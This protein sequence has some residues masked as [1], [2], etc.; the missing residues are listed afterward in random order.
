MIVVFALKAERD[1]EAIGDWIAKDNPLR[2]VSFVQE[3]KQACDRVLSAPHGYPLV[4]RYKHLEIRRRS[5]GD[6]LVFYR[7]SA[8]WIEIL[9]ILHGARDYETILAQDFE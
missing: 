3:V 4:Q 5:Y 9:R 6:Y 2:A 8:K 7:V 1:L